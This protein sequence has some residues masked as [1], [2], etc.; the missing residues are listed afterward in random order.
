VEW[1]TVTEGH[2]LHFEVSLAGQAVAGTAAQKV[3]P[4]QGQVAAVCLGQGIIISQQAPARFRQMGHGPQQ[5]LTIGQER[6]QGGGGDI[7]GGK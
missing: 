1:L 5:I 7:H 3:E 2:F 4:I 6:G